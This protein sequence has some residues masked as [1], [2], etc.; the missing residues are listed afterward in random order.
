MS[1]RSH[2][3][4]VDLSY[5]CSLFGGGGHKSA[6]AFSQRKKFFDKII[7]SQIN[8]YYDIQKMNI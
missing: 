4:D 7:I 3:K 6:A 2:S 5:I 1:L 8:L